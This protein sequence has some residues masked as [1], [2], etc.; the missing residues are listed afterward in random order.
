MK[1]EIRGRIE[2]T[3]FR[4]KVH[5]VEVI[6][7]AED[8]YSKPSSFIV[9]SAVAL[10]NVGEEVA[11]VCSVDGFT[12][13]RPYKDKNTGEMKEFVDSPVFF[14]YVESI[15]SSKQVAPRSAA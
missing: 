5:H 4:D 12:K 15:A 7:A 6:C 10:G 14:N 11:I 2:S 13:R 8:L 1:V 3:N 9:R